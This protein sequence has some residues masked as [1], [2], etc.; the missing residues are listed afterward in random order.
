MK[1]I[2]ITLFVLLTVE[3]STQSKKQE[4]FIASTGFVGGA[5][6]TLAPAFPVLLVPGLCLV[7]TSMIT[8][9]YKKSYGPGMVVN[10]VK[11]LG[12]EL[13]SKKSCAN[14]PSYYQ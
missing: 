1:I 10:S 14:Y 3:A 7:A 6:I 12:I 2:L 11:I 9:T 4:M 8:V 5:C 13:K